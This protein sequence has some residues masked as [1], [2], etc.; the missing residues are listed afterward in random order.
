MESILQLWLEQRVFVALEKIIIG[1]MENGMTHVFLKTFVSGATTIRNSL[2]AILIIAGGLFT[3]GL[4]SSQTVLGAPPDFFKSRLS[5]VEAAVKEVQKGKVRQIAESVGGR[6]IYLVTY[7]EK[8][9]LESTANYNSACGGRDPASYRRKDGNQKPVVF[10]LGPVHGQEF[11]G[12]ASMVNLLRI[13]ETGRDWRGREWPE[14]TEHLSRCRVLIVP[15]GNPDG[16]ALC[17]YDS[18]VGETLEATQR[19]GM[20]VQS[21]G[22]NFVYPFVKR[23]HPQQGPTVK[24]R[25]AYFNDG[26]VNMMH[27]YWFDPMAMET[28]AFFRIARNEAPDYIVSL[29]SRPSVPCLLQTS[30]VSRTVKETIANLSNRVVQRYVEAGLPHQE[31]PMD[32]QGDGLGIPPSF[33]LSSALHHT[34]GAVSFIHECMRGVDDPLYPKITHEQILDIDLLMVDELLKYAVEHPVNWVK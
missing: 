29:H 21:C 14:I 18:W 7:G 22:D 23:L 20:G 2:N 1:N 16:R 24:V 12:V 26:G 15:C 8:D 3:W 25:G 13:A 19:I 4:T 31:K 34:C 32:P 5:D 33:N 9:D 28:R 27:D 6:P 17:S 30:Y 10:F 11:E